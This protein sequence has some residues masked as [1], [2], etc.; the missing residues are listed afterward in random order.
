MTLQP[1]EHFRP[2]VRLLQQKKTA[3][4]QFLGQL[5]V[6]VEL[7][8]ETAQD[9]LV[10]APRPTN[11]PSIRTDARENVRVKNSYD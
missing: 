6:G 10:Q 3:E 2:V 11:L 8:P 5:I 4:E 9:A 1:L 7:E